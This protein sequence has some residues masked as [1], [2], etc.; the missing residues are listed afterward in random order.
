MYN[1]N[2]CD[3]IMLIIYYHVYLHTCI[4]D[5]LLLLAYIGVFYILIYADIFGFSPSFLDHTV[6]YPEKHYQFIISGRVR[7]LCL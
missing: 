4:F 1:A 2:E 7:V 6:R 3:K 5:Y